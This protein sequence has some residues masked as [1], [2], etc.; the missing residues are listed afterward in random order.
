MKM[1]RN[2]CPNCYKSRA[3]YGLVRMHAKCPNCGY[4]YERE[5]GYFLG[6]M[7]VSYLLGAFSVVPTLLLG[8]F[9][10]ELQMPAIILIAT[11]QLSILA[12]LLF[13]YS[14]LIWIHL[15]HRADPSRQR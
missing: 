3:F 6:A 1:F 12:P 8:I 9:V 10:W 4:V 15:D 7:V 13:R 5:P 14:R 11:L 2:L